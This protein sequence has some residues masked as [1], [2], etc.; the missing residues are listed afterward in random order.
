MITPNYPFSDDIPALII[1]STSNKLLA[2]IVLN[3]K[4]KNQ[5]IN[6]IFLYKCTFKILTYQEF[7]ICF[8]TQ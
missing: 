5:K 1:S 3:K 8:L 7:K 2:I 4:T 6:I